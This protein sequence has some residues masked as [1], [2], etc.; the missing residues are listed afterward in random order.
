MH[1][2]RS[3]PAMAL[4]IALSA[5]MP[6]T[7]AAEPR[8]DGV[9]LQ[10]MVREFNAICSE[11]QGIRFDLQQRSLDERAFGDRIL[12]LFVREDS[13][14]TL[15]DDEVPAERRAGSP[16]FALEWALRHLNESLRENYEGIVEKN[17]YR[18]VTADIALEAAE[19]WKGSLGDEP[20]ALP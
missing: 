6:G 19:A 20:G 1:H 5:A 4:A 15:L 18:F 17:G 11:L 2:A 3:L 8:T 9:D 16:A 12:D 10:G 7:G 14:R 13:I